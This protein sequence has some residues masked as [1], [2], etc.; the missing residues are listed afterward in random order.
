MS[1]LNTSIKIG[2]LKLNNRLVMPP[3]ATA[4][5]NDDGL[6]TDRVIDYYK[7]KNTDILKSSQSRLR[8]MYLFQLY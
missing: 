5:C 6:I 7:E 8:S 1:L 4:K 2:N 3:I